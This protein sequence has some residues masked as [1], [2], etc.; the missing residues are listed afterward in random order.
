MNFVDTEF[1]REMVEN[2]IKEVRHVH[3]VTQCDLNEDGFLDFQEFFKM[4][5]SNSRK[6][7]TL[8]SAFNKA[9]SIF[10]RRSGE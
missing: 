7:E 5:K 4:M 10:S 2:I 3:V 6:K 8:P 1:D 9:K